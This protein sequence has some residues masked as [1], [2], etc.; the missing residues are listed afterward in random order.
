MPE[1]LNPSGIAW[2]ALVPL[3]V[4]PYLLRQKPRRRVVPALF[5][6]AG[7]EPASRVRLG[8]RF[9]FQPLFLL[10]LLLLLL[11]A[12]AILR[13]AFRTPEVRAA[14]V[15]DDSASLQARSTSGE[16]RFAAVLR[17]AAA[18]I[19][20]NPANT[21]DLY[22]LSPHPREL[23]IGLGASQ[24]RSRLASLTPGACAHPD[25]A[26][27]SAFFDGLATR[28][29]ASTHVVTDRAGTSTDHFR[30]ASVGEPQPNVAITDLALTPPALSETHATLNVVVENFSSAA[31]SVPIAVS[32]DA[33]KTIR[34]GK[35]AI[36][37]H[38]TATFGADVPTSGR[39]HARIDA[40]D[41]LPLD[42]E[43]SISADPRGRARILVVDK[44]G[45]GLDRLGPLL[46]AD[47]EVVA[48]TRYRPE[49]AQGRSLVV[50]HLSAP[51]EPPAVPAL[52][53][54]PPPA[55]FLPTVG[56]SIDKPAIAFPLPTHPIARYLNAAALRPRQV[57]A[58]KDQTGWQPLAL[59]NG[60]AV[61]LERP[62]LVRSV[63]S[64]FDLLPYL[65]D[66]NRPVSILTLNLL[67]WMLRSEPRE[68]AAGTESCSPIG[69]GESD[70]EHRASLPAPPREAATHEPTTRTNALWPWLTLAVIV[71]LVL[72]AISQRGAP[73]IAWILRALT[74]ALLVGAWLDPARDI[75][76]P[77]PPPVV[78][79]DASRSVV[80]SARDEM[81]AQLHDAAP[82]G[83]PVVAFAATQKRTSL[84]ALRGAT[85]GVD[86]QA[87]DLESALLAGA[88][89]GT[90]GAPVF[91]LSDGWETR[92]DAL[93]AADALARRKLRVYPIAAGGA[94]EHKV[95]VS[96]LS[97]PAESAAGKALRAE[98]LLRNDNPSAVTG[99]LLLRRGGTELSR[100]TVTLPPGDTVVAR[101]LLLSGEGLIEFAAE[102]QPSLPAT[103]SDRSDDVA[104]AWVVASS[105]RKIVLV[106]HEARDNK[107][108]ERALAQR[109]F[110]VSSVERAAG[111]P[112]PG[113][114]STTAVVLNDVALSELGGSADEIRDY[115]RGG[116][117]LLMVG[118]PRSFGLGGYRGSPIEEALPVR[119]KERRRDEPRNSVALVIDKSG[120]MRE[121]QRILFAREAANQLVEKL[122]DRDRIAVIGFDR[123]AFVVVPMSEAGEIR[124][125]FPRRI[126]RL[127]PEGGTRLYPALEEAR[128]Q[129]LSEESKRRH[130][131]VLSD[132]LS[133]DAE[134]SGGRR[135]Y[136]DLALALA[137]QGVTI[138]TIA[139]GHDADGD[140]LERLASFGRGAFHETSDSSSLPEIV[141]GEFEEH[142][143][144]KTVSEQEYRP[145]PSRESPVVGPLAASDP[146][147][148]DVLGLVETE[149]KPG[150]RLDVGVAESELPLIASWE[151]GR[152]RAA[153]VTTDADGR[154]SDR[155]V[156]WS[157]WSR[158][159]ADLATWLAPEQKGAQARFALAYRDGAIEID[160]SRFDRDPA[161]A[162]VAKVS[163]PGGK[164]GDVALVRVAAGH[165]RGRYVTELA[166]DYRIEIRSA[167]GGAITQTALGYT[168]PASQVGERPRRDPNWP[169]LE[170]IARRTGGEVNAKVE[171]V[172]PAPA[173][174]ASIPLAPSLLAA[175]MMM[176]LLELVVRRL[177]AA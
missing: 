167:D 172:K 132:G 174:E 31:A 48:P 104:K 6:Y 130:I 95:E 39:F 86:P 27:V 152:G 121:E 173:T 21:W 92:G 14:L 113:L 115:V 46:G 80:A 34:E 44:D 38:A 143:K 136:Y 168:I 116:G 60:G 26:M 137:D 19:A 5:L 72:D 153:A 128:R 85:E 112:M 90:P 138:S 131:I 129:L 91:L 149:L 41:A 176:L 50:F 98:V 159:W 8:G 22:A 18:E 73:V 56:A 139:L 11:A 3:L 99:R 74:A 13:P 36:A 125:D 108:L 63:V 47:V 62:G 71:L 78:L 164:P 141:L 162:I 4:V 83:A 145:R 57:V 107:N 87:T 140:F 28:G 123:E 69:R 157:E 147:W 148:P 154:W 93:R 15:I 151:Y 32:E 100:E 76:G 42:D 61:V 23:G 79:V 97:L 70:L 16:S 64:G 51:H 161:G 89:A 165:Y 77:V 81:L 124:D 134:D 24:A 101:P 177:R 33:G 45:G 88:N 118:G 49:L 163:P 171:D 155:W 109:G 12:A 169:L 106:G 111:E 127:R 158:L 29:Y 166:G 58:L 7:I 67:S 20:R 2:L 110:K 114:S 9:R 122:K 25:D 66:R 84:A 94:V 103:D 82:P 119:M 96:A 52:Y 126:E 135:R 68:A 10:Q 120:S 17:E 156:R 65:G 54:L 53:L 40:K 146:H 55:P 105:T 30:F 1:L 170:E 75:P 35:L 150:A 117:G 59:A 43:A 37:P 102:F 160:Y 175:A 144:E 142:A 133:E